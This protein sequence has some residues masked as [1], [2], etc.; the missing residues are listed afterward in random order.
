M[1]MKQLLIINA[2]IDKSPVTAA[3][4]NAYRA[5]AEQ[6]EASVKEIN[7]ADMI[8]NP[9]K[10]FFNKAQELEPSLQ[11]AVNN[12]KWAS[13]I[14]VFCPVYKNSIHSR[15]KGFFD[16]IFMPDQIFTH[17]NFRGKT[18]RI[19]SVL[20][21]EAWNDWQVNQQVT[22]LS[23]KKNVLEHAY[24]KPVHTSTIGYL[25]D[26]NNEYA[27]KWLQKLFNFGLKL[28]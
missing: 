12:I 6:S 28:I 17:N 1:L 21:E 15:I 7:I 26:L 19:V 3:L 24:I 10:Q 5:G 11:D 27:K 8:F 4:I 2:D 14:V 25:Y 22:Y 23:I 13:H 20:D 9:N 18:A 16:R